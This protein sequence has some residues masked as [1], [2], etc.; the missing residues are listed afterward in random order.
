MLWFD[1]NRDPPRRPRIFAQKFRG[2]YRE[3]ILI[4]VLASCWIL[5]VDDP[6]RGPR[7]WAIGFAS[8]DD[9]FLVLRVPVAIR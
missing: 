7:A 8:S 3:E 9:D 6:R 5:E 2:R 1:F 4:P